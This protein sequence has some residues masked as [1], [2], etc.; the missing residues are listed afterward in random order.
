MMDVGSGP[1]AN[2]IH[3]LEDRCHPL[4]SS[5]SSSSSSPVVFAVVS[6]FQQDG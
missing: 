5:L 3:N 2:C 6:P 1:W 4:V